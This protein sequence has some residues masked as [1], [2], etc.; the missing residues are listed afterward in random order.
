MRQ[1][2]YNLRALHTSVISHELWDNNEFSFED[3]FVSY[4]LIAD[5]NNISMVKTSLAKQ[6]EQEF[7]YCELRKLDW[8]KQCIAARQD[9]P[10]PLG[11]R[12][13]QMVEEDT[14]RADQW[15]AT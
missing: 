5:Y 13:N 2:E 12:L 4:Y 11:R 3:L 1:V 9:V 10:D 14:S 7:S 8:A 15:V 6:W